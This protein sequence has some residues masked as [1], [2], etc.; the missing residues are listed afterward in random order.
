MGYDKNVHKFQAVGIK[1]TKKM[2]GQGQIKAHFS[3]G[4]GSFRR[5]VGEQF[6]RPMSQLFEVFFGGRKPEILTA[7]RAV[8][9]ESQASSST[10]SVL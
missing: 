1:C 4:Y 10:V 3:T 7:L 5:A 2:T 8:L 6:G 9:T